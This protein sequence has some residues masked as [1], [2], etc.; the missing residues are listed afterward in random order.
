MRAYLLVGA[1][2]FTAGFGWHVWPK[3]K[4]VEAIASMPQAKSQESSA[5]AAG[6]SSENEEKPKAEKHS[7]P[8]PAT[9][10]STTP[11]GSPHGEAKTGGDATG[12]G[13]SSA[14]GPTTF[15]AGNGRDTNGAANGGARGNTALTPPGVQSTAGSS[16]P[17]VGSVTQGPCSSLQIGGSYNQSTVNCAPPLKPFP[18]VNC[19]QEGVEPGK[20]LNI[21]MEIGP[22]REEIDR[23]EK[24]LRNPGVILSC[25]LDD[26]WSPPVFAAICDR[27]CES[28][29]AVTA[30]SFSQCGRQRLG[31]GGEGEVL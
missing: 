30:H 17:A 7:K 12:N 13:S 8:K 27:P 23:R 29:R 1:V 5:Q 15:A 18:R 31:T 11:D 10:D 6:A 20:E 26:S 22:S 28:M 16:S 19:S 2:L 14:G 9:H 25:S 4:G 3:R 21:G 24:F